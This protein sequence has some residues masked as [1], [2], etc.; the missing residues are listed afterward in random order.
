MLCLDHLA[1]ITNVNVKIHKDT[2]GVN[3]ER[4]QHG[5]TG[6]E[7]MIFDLNNST[8]TG[9]YGIRETTSIDVLFDVPITLDIGDSVTIGAILLAINAV[10]ELNPPKRHPILSSNVLLTW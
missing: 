1:P 7:D 6:N 4:I 10:L 5:S 8:K 3:G 9:D 2:I